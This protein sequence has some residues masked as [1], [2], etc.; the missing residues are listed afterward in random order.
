[1]NFVNARKMSKEQKESK[2]VWSRQ[3]KRSLQ[4]RRSNMVNGI[5]VILVMIVF[6]S[7]M[8]NAIGD[9]KSDK[10]EKN[11]ELAKKTEAYEEESKRTE[12]LENERLYVQT[13]KY[14]EDEARKLGFVYPGEI[15]LK[16]EQ[17][18]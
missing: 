2:A 5:A 7:I 9:L 13:K 6:I 18:D 8:A 3:N 4:K 11:E 17:K 1:M 16:P 10:K 15:I 14:V 12:E